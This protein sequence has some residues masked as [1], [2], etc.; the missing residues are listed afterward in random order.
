MATLVPNTAHGDLAARM[1]RGVPLG[2]DVAEVT[3]DSLHTEHAQHR[4]GQLLDDLRIRGADADGDLGAR[5]RSRR[6]S[7]CSRPGSSTRSS[8]PPSRST[9]RNGSGWTSPPAA[10]PHR[11]AGDDHHRQPREVKLPTSKGRRDGTD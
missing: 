7:G 10:P 6:W 11:A 4:L 2:H 5:T 9:S 1:A 3:A 8:C